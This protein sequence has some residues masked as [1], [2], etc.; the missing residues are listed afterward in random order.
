LVAPAPVLERVLLSLG[1]SPTNIGKAHQAWSRLPIA[2][3]RRI[4]VVPGL[5]ALVIATLFAGAATYISIVE[6]PARMG[7]ED[8]PLLAQW[9]PSYK[10][11]LPIQ[12]ALAMLG[13]AAGLLAWYSF[14]EWQWMAGSLLLL[15]NWP[16]TLLVIM[17]VNKPL[18][19]MAP[20]EAGAKS[21][22]LLRRWGKLHGVRSMLGS[23]ASLL[24]AWGFLAAH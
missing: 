5:V 11:A 13:G 6:H 23:A 14:R 20:E 22:S 21:R 18:M 7:L 17:P 1:V 4:E 3:Q 19:A 15:A 2:N 12:A 16:F 9:Q 8:A 10:R 24:F